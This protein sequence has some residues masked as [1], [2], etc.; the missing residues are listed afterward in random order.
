MQTISQQIAARA[1][2][3][4]DDVTATRMAQIVKQTSHWN[5]YTPRFRM[6]EM[7]TDIE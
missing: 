7:I 4:A 5:L 6:R 2:N 3:C 1:R